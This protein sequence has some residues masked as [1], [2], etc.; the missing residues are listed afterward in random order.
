MRSV[1]FSFPLPSSFTLTRA[2]VSLDVHVV[3]G[4]VIDLGLRGF[5]LDGARTH[6]QQQV[7]PSVQQ[8]HRKEVHLVALLTFYVPPVLRLPMGE[9]DQPVGLGGAKVKGDGGHAFS[10]PL[11]QRQVGLGR[12]KGDGVEGGNVFTLKNYVSLE[13]HLGVHDAGQPGQFQADIIVLVDH[14][15]EN[16]DI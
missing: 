16:K 3:P 1:T 4:A 14:L 5:H 12:L 8:L 2:S 15:V 13:F 10:V 11:G 9:Q 6:V 7:Q